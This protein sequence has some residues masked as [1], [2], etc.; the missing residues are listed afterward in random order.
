MWTWFHKLASPPHFYRIAG[1]VIPWFSWP[2]LILILLGLYG[3]LVMAPSR[4]P[5][6]W[7]W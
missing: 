2:A 6:A 7:P 1:K 5:A 3:G 4:P